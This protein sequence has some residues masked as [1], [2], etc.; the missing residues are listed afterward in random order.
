MNNHPRAFQHTDIYV[1]NVH[2]LGIIRAMRSI[3]L[4]RL[5]MPSDGNFGLCLAVVA[6]TTAGA[7][8]VEA[9]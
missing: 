5:Q 6:I 7:G 2:P 9:P 8:Q 4:T 1:D 3:D